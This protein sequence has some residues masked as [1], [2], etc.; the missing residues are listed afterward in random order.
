M[1]RIEA[2]NELF[3]RHF[4]HHRFPLKTKEIVHFSGYSMNS[5]CIFRMNSEH[6]GMQ[7]GYRRAVSDGR[8]IVGIPPNEIVFNISMAITG[9]IPWISIHL[10]ANYLIAS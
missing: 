9:C 10:Q 3:M 5:L 7:V 1:M 8:N 2:S 6:T 4:G